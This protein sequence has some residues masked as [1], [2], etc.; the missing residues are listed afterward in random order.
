M[1]YIQLGE[2]RVSVLGLGTSRLASIDPRR[3]NGL[4]KRLLN[5]A[6]ERGVNL[7]DT[8]DTY[9]SG[10]AERLV[11][12]AIADQGVPIYIATKGGYPLFD[13]PGPFRIFNQYGKKARQLWGVKQDFS[14]ST[15]AQRIEGSLRRLGVDIIDVYFLHEPPVE[16]LCNDDL[17]E[18]LDQAVSAGKIRY[19]GV[20]SD[21]PKVVRQAEVDERWRVLQSK[22]GIMRTSVPLIV[23]QAL[24]SASNH[25][26]ATAARV[27]EERNVSPAAL[28][29]RHAAAAGGP[30]VVLSRTSSL[31]H[32]CDNTDAFAEPITQSDVLI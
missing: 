3:F 32:L 27:A 19:L 16:A 18:A 21:D 14:P 24:S 11:G 13:L 2:L 12:R 29:L 30:R 20:S 10:A 6:F 26:R 31:Y 28:L 25:L 23:N 8:A 7:V 22:L 17:L 15:I 5:A 9:G 1:Q 4:P